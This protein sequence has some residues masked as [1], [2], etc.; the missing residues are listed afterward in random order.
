MEPG[1][2][3][4][5][6]RAAT[7]GRTDDGRYGHGRA[8]HERADAGFT[9]IE[10]LTVLAI[11]LL[12]AALLL[13]VQMRARASARSA[14]C[15]NNLHQA[16]IA[17][18]LYLDDSGSVLPVAASLP[19]AH[20]NE[21]PPISTALGPYLGDPDVLRCPADTGGR[22][23]FSEGSSYEYNAMMSGRTVRSLPAVQRVGESRVPVMYDYEPFHGRAGRPGAANYL[24]AD[25]H[26]GDFD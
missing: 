13:P 8:G 22:Y 18:S 9:L 1:R 25:G 24:F 3:T 16:G 21:D 20:L 10:L 19:S 2:N 14:H 5:T 11:I 7:A 12:L 15:R 23:F 17:I 4:T 6:G 26:V